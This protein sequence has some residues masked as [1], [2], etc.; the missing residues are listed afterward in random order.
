MNDLFWLNPFLSTSK[1]EPILREV[2]TGWEAG[3]GIFSFLASQTTLPWASDTSVDNSVLD[4]AYFGNHSGGKFCA[5]LVKALLNTDG[6]VPSSARVTIA[7][8]LISKYLPN[9]RHLWETNV[10]AYTPI[11]NYDMT[12]NRNLKTANSA[13]ESESGVNSHTGTDTF[14]HG[15]IETTDHGKI[16]DGIDYKYGINTVDDEPKPSDKSR[17]EESGD[18]VVTNS[19]S[20]VDTKNL[21]DTSTNNKNS[22][23]A[24]EEDEVIHRAGNIGVT[25]TQKLLQEERALWIW[26]F[27]DQV[28]KDL[29]NELALCFHDSCR[30]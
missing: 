29:D 28:F 3:T 25:T 8:I 27:F 4:I 19:G 17:V 30:V 16:T 26:N 13:A 2:F 12:E 9:W 6:E 23:G 11:H 14:Q 10:V 5:P 22:V 21:Q 20:D 1:P 18:T 15:L 7:K 24:T